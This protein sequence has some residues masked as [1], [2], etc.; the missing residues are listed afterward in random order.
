[1]LLSRF[2]PRSESTIGL[3]AG[4][5]AFIIWGS[6]VLYWKTLAHVHSVDVVAYRT[7]WSVITL[8][9]FTG[10]AHRWG[11]VRVAIVN[12]SVML[13]L[14]VSA[15]TLSTTWLIFIW[16]VTHNRVIEASLGNF[17][18]PL[19]SV[20]VGRVLLKERLTRLQFL[21]IAIAMVGVLWSVVGYGQVPWIALVLSSFF[22]MYGFW[23]K[24]VAVESIPGLFLE[25]LLLCP[26]AVAWLVWQGFS[27]GVLFFDYSFGTQLLL[28]GSGLVTTVPLLLF[29]YA[30]RHLS[31]ANT[32][33]L[34]YISPSISL[35]VGIYIFGET[36][37]TATAVTLGFI[38]VGLFVYTWCSMRQW[39]MLPLP[40]PSE[41]AE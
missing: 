20:L 30:S 41:E 4:I 14:F 17:I 34:Q 33:L 26:L 36:F 13:R 32:G 8:I 35:F 38:W 1:M 39:R 7:F 5:S 24:T 28:M 12:P 15:V 10:I 40:K 31:L 37:T 19:M 6:L 3:I 23:R 16:A 18:T 25:T 29:I 27:G 2:M 11:E 22:A 9:C 21:A